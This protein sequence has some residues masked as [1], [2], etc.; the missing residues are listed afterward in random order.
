[1]EGARAKGPSLAS[2]PALYLDNMSVSAIMK[3]FRIRGTGPLV[4]FR[5][6]NGWNM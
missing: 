3:E 5:V 4:N 1:M 2:T 6:G